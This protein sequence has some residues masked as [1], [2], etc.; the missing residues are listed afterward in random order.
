MKS[1]KIDI[2]DVVSGLFALVLFSVILMAVYSLY[3]L[4][5]HMPPL[6]DSRV[7]NGAV[8]YREPDESFYGSLPLPQSSPGPE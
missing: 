6:K 3:K 5:D 8:M 4:S 7:L 1:R 2:I